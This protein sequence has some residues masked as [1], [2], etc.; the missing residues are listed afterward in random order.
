MPSRLA[1]FVLRTLF[2]TGICVC[3]VWAAGSPSTTQSAQLAHNIQA[4]REAATDPT[5]T[6]EISEATM[7][8]I[9][10]MLKGRYAVRFG[11]ED[12][13][14]TPNDMITLGQLIE[15]LDSAA[16]TRPLTKFEE[17]RRG[18]ARRELQAGIS[19]TSSFDIAFWRRTGRFSAPSMEALLDDLF[20][21]SPY[22]WSVHNGTFYIRPLKGSLLNFPVSLDVRDLS[23]NQVVGQILDQQPASESK[24]VRMSMG[25][26][27]SD[28]TFVHR[29]ILKDVAASDALCRAVEASNPTMSWN[30]SGIQ[31][32]RLFSIDKQQLNEDGQ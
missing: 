8:D 28:K 23:I 16:T 27:D 19:K 2:I 15:Q 31:G 32:H 25:K 6:A 20:L 21:K 3:E 14:Y 12:I 17:T 18:L 30:L 4:T 29:L 5:F 13:D 11:C 9:V 26:D 7:N 22:I 24:I 10:R 1:V